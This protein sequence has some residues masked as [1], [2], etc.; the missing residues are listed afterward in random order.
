MRTDRDE[1]LKAA[2]TAVTL[3]GGIDV[4]HKKGLN[5]RLV[6]PLM[7]ADID[8]DLSGLRTFASRMGISG[9]PKKEPLPTEPLMEQHVA[10]WWMI[11]T[12][13]A[14]EKDGILM[15]TATDHVSMAGFR[16][17]TSMQPQ[18]LSEAYYAV[19][20]A[21]VPF[22]P[23]GLSATAEVAISEYKKA[24]PKHKPV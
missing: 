16:I 8:D 17:A 2:V 7:D 4:L 22:T 6:A 14:K 3:M 15:L 13:R 23:A 24:H 5:L 1:N 10:E 12:G 18:R 9:S 20:T 11:K 19:S 21:E